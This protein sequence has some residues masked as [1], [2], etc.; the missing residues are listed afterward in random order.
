[1]P[2]PSGHTREASERSR[3]RSSSDAMRR[4]IPMKS[5]VGR[6]T[7]SRPGSVTYPVTRAPLLPPG[8][9]TI[10]TSVSCPRFKRFSIGCPLTRAFTRSASVP[11][12]ED[13][14]AKSSAARKAFLSSPMSINA[15]CMP[16]STF[17]TRPR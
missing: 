4:L 1:M 10:C 15:A 8:T 17:S 13:A 3:A 2:M 6:S 16:G 12:S 11:K 14:N 9:F 7:T 5:T